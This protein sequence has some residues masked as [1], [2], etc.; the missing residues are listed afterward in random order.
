[1]QMYNHFLLI[2]LSTILTLEG[3]F[4]SAKTAFLI[5]PISS[6]E[7]VAD[8]IPPP[9][10]DEYNLMEDTPESSETANNYLKNQL[11]RKIIE[12]AHHVPMFSLN[13]LTSKLQQFQESHH[14]NGNTLSNREEML[15]INISRKRGLSMLAR[16][17]PFSDLGR[18]RTPIRS[19]GDFKTVYGTD[20]LDVVSAQTRARPAGQPLRWG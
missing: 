9:W 12:N 14:N 11:A 6:D 8:D 10:N 2:V 19:A 5:S 3:N 13:D 18:D 16:W 15:P 4:I 20:L 17:K 7:A 1:M